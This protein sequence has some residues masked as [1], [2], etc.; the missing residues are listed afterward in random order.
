MRFTLASLR[1]VVYEQGG[2]DTEDLGRLTNE[3]LSRIHSIMELLSDRLNHG[4][5]KETPLL[6]GGTI[7]E[8]LESNPEEDSPFLEERDQM[9]TWTATGT[10]TWSRA[11]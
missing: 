8:I 9:E 7:A 6:E 10:E 4:D 5:M 1:D 3:Y 11:P 2:R